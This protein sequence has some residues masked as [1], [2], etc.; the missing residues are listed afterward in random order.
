MKVKKFSYITPVLA[1]L[2]WL[3]IQPRADFKVLYKAISNLAPAYL[4]VHL[5][6]YVPVAARTLGSMSA[7]LLTIPCVKKTAGHTVDI[8]LSVH[9]HSGTALHYASEKLSGYF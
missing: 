2:H 6:P 5:E 4:S 1:S 7:G 9:P 8:L 3:P